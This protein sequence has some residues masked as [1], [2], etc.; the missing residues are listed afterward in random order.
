MTSQK[1]TGS[2]YTPKRLADY[3][4]Y[5][6]FGEIGNGYK[7]DDLTLDVLEPSVGGGM[8]LDSLLNGNY[9]AIKQPFKTATPKII[10]IICT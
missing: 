5:R 2:Y 4:V 1:N 6:L 7:F 10:R 9:Y 8:F 3:I